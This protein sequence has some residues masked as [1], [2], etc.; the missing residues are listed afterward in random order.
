MWN[1]TTST[2]ASGLAE[3]VERLT[4]EEKRAFAQLINW[5]DLQRLRIEVPR[6]PALLPVGDPRLYVETTQD[7]LGLDLPLEHTSAFIAMLPDKLASEVVDIFVQNGQGA[8]E[9]SC[10]P[11]DLAAWLEGHE[12]AVRAGAIMLEFGPHTL[13][14]AG[15]GCLS[16]SLTDAPPPLRREIAQQALALCG[17][18][19]DFQADH[20]SA[21][22]WKDQLEVTE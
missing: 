16:L 6:T 15:G 21:I 18:P 7:G 12:E 13:I 5:E 2:V 4:V 3:I 14:S 19:Y 8:Q 17:F 20:F 9:V 22:V 11:A 1:G 10:L